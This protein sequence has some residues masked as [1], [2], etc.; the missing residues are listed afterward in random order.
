MTMRF[1]VVQWPREYGVLRYTAQLIDPELIS[2][3]VRICVQTSG[4]QAAH[5]IANKANVM[6]ARL[7]AQGV[8][9][10]GI[11]T[12]EWVRMLNHVVGEVKEKVEGTVVPEGND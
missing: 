10:P 11:K 12:G 5:S 9:H 3:P 6:L 8:E 7:R 2:L 4:W 1:A